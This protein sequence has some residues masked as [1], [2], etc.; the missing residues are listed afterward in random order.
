[1]N[2]P[3]NLLSPPEGE[4]VGKS[5]ITP[6]GFGPVIFFGSN[7]LRAFW[8]LLLFL[9]LAYFFTLF[10]SVFL[11][12]LG[13]NPA[14][15]A[16]P[17]RILLDDGSMFLGAL[18]AAILMSLAEG[19]SLAFYGL[20]RQGAFG[21]QFALGVLWALIALTSLL[22]AI[23]ALGGFSFGSLALTGNSLATSGILWA[24]AFLTVAFCEE[25]LAR[26]YV[27]Y[28]LSTGMGFW[29][30]AVLLSIAFGSVHLRNV[31]EDWT[32]ALAAASIGFFWCLTVRRTGS[33]WFAIGM[34][35]AWDFSE[36][37]IFSCPDSGIVVEGHL[38]NSSFQ[39]PR[40]L[41]GGSVGPEGSVLAF[42]LV[43]VLFAV[44]N[45]LY[46]ETKF[47]AEAHEESRSVAIDDSTPPNGGKQ[48]AAP[49]GLQASD[50]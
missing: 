28:T 29:P 7:G 23:S 50:H 20:P 27:L 38:L 3:A 36:S 14:E 5:A 43:A 12:L 32:G 9:T 1:M 18:T 15:S 19:R 39:G 6:T 40:W 34:H 8:R 42:V 45:R 33:L 26:G 16:N 47:P 2:D 35:A 46:P 10:F 48:Q 49:N 25:F 11:R 21:K 37:F 13:F 24:A 30:A 41:T 4:P 31:G 17:G 22:I 44:F